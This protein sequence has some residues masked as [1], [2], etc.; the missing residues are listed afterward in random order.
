MALLTMKTFTLNRTNMT[1]GNQYK[2]N[3][4]EAYA[5]FLAYI[6]SEPGKSWIK[7]MGKLGVKEQTATIAMA[8]AFEN[9][10]ISSEFNHEIKRNAQN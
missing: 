2:F 10:F 7:Q 8:G 3:N 1:I 5:A 4:K 6:I 9:G